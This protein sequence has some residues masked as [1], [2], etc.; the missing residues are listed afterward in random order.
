MN[1]FKMFSNVSSV[2]I[3]RFAEITTSNRS[4]NKTTSS[5]TTTLTTQYSSIGY[6]L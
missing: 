1:R 2:A 5:T 3:T 6:F 4:S